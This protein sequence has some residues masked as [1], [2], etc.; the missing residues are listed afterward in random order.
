MP[1]SRFPFTGL[2]LALLFT[3]AA[4]AQ[5]HENSRAIEAV[6]GEPA[7]LLARASQPVLGLPPL[8]IPAANPLTEEKIALGRK[9]FFDRRLSFNRTLSCAMCH[10]PEQGFAQVELKTPVGIEGRF[11]KRNAPTLLNVGYRQHLFHDGREQSLEHQVWQPLLKTNEMANPSIGFVLETIRNAEDYAGL[12]E[13]A[14]P[15][16]LTLEAVGQAL[17]SYQRVLV[18]GDSDFDRW[19]F[20]KQEGALSEDAQRGWVL[21]QTTGCVRCHQVDTQTAQFTDGQFHDTGIGYARSMGIGQTPARV[22]LAPGVEVVPT[23][24]FE[25]PTVNDLGRY[26]ATGLSEDR[27]KYRTP[28][29]RNVALTPPYMHDGSLP[30]LMAVVE[31]YAAGG[32]PHE[33]QDWRVRPLEL[34]EDD[35]RALVAFMESLTGRDVETLVRDARSEGIGN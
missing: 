34:T 13:A 12:F 35:K 15:T 16:G 22:R 9:L 17:A 14:F 1:A 23:V 25:M 11:V 24:S 5:N 30:N 2:V 6:G 8:P 20:G 4:G 31:Y 3:S 7:A 21:F 29:L 33:G 18:A 26:E 10:V 28:S 32:I 27:W 19:Y